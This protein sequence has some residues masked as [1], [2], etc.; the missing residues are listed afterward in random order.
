MGEV[1]TGRSPTPERI[2]AQVE[3]WRTSEDGSLT[4][5]SLFLLVI[6]L[7]FAG[8]AVDLMRYETRCVS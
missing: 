6:M 8:M 2:S 5:F 7:F 3:F 1:T 4:I